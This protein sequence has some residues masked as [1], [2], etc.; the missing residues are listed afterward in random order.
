VSAALR[1]VAADDRFREA[2]TWQSRGAL[3]G[4]V[5]A[6]LRQPITATDDKTRQQEQLVAGYL[7]RY[8]TKNDTIGFFGPIGWAQLVREG[9]LEARPGKSLLSGRKV[10]FEYWPIDTLAERL[11]EDLKTLLAPRLLPGVWLD[12]D[13][14]HYPVDK[15]AQVGDDVMRLLSR[16]DGRKSAQALAAE[17]GFDDESEC[18]ALLSELEEKKLIRWALEVPSHPFH[19]DQELRR[20]LLALP[21]DEAQKRALGTVDELVRARDVVAQ[22]AGDSRRVDDAL[23]DCEQ[24]FTRLCEHATVRSGQ[25][26]GLL[27]EDCVRDL[28]LRIPDEALAGLGAPLSLLLLSARWFSWELARRYRAALEALHASLA[29]E[30]GSPVID[31]MRFWAKAAELLSDNPRRPSPL[32]DEVK[33]EVER[34]WSEILALDPAAKRVSLSAEQL[35]AQVAAAFAAPRPGWPD[36]RFHSPDLMMIVEPGRSTFVLGELH[37]GQNTVCMPL[38][39]EH[40]PAPPELHA[41]FRRSLGPRL[42]PVK[43]RQT[44][45]R[46]TYTSPWSDDLDVETSTARSARPDEQVLRV[47]DLVV[48][49]GGRSV[50][51][52][53]G[54]RRF[55]VLEFF[56]SNLTQNLGELRILPP[57]PHLPR[58]TI[59]GLVV[60]RERWQFAP[61]DLAFAREAKPADRFLGAARFA[62]KQQLPRFVFVKI[63]EEEKPH[64][65][66]LESPI[67]VELLAKFARKA[68]AI[69]FSEMLPSL[70]QVWLPD[71][72]GNRYTWE[73]RTAAV[74]PEPWQP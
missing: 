57:A 74:D 27:S 2:V 46:R 67:Y 45:D 40:H 26:R 37:C 69:T 10:F 71:A 49:D 70:D 50:R 44:V 43:L 62:A 14:L 5:D 8:C 51:T 15:T 53:D 61:A 3:R 24:L 64:Y 17:L 60:A 19:P 33:R 48:D 72:E 52:R 38:F 12:G 39:V 66:D 73:L 56:G 13:Q 47:G 30:T 21:E 63:P 22:A 36:A 1:A 31:L 16:C 59:D 41:L 28:E 29:A 7:Q 4:S 23:R 65:I 32:V 25:A 6:L 68:S 42:E 35:Q 18:Y 11:S 9:A 34:R 20:L 54:K 55:D 58:V